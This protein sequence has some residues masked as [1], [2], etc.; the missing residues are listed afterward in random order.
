MDLRT[1]AYYT[2]FLDTG[3][4]ILGLLWKAGYKT[5]KASPCR[6]I[7]LKKS[8]KIIKKLLHAIIK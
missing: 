7:I 2:E 1:L 3:F 5:L 4:D 6:D 8:Q